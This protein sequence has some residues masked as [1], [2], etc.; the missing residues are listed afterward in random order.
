MLET[1]QANST[2]V[3]LGKAVTLEGD[4]EGKVSNHRPTKMPVVPEGCHLI[5]RLVIRGASLY[6]VIKGLKA[7]QGL[8]D[9]THATRPD[10]YPAE[11]I[12][13]TVSNY[14]VPTTE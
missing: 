3:Y 11:L 1:P 4:Q 8:W 9:I 10:I 7:L 6:F 12:L 14:S 13:Y 5:G 2:F